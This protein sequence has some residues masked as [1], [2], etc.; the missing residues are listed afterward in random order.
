M[1]KEQA[2]RE[3]LLVKLQLVQHIIE[4][5]IQLYKNKRE[6]VEYLFLKAN[7][8]PDFTRIVWQRL[9][10]ESP[11]FF[12]AYHLRMVLRD[13][14]R[15]YNELYEK[16]VELVRR[17]GRSVPSS[18]N[19]SRMHSMHNDSGNQT[20]QP[21]ENVPGDGV[22]ALQPTPVNMSVPENVL[23][24]QHSIGQG[25]NDVMIGSNSEGGFMNNLIEAPNT[26]G[27]PYVTPFTSTSYPMETSSFGQ[28]THNFSP[29][30]NFS[31]DRSAL[32]SY[33]LQPSMQVPVSMSVPENMLLTQNSFGQ[34]MNSAMIESNSEGGFLNN[35]IEA[36]DTIGEAYVTPFTSTG[37]PM[38]T[39]SFG[40]T[41][42]NFSSTTNFSYDTSALDSYSLSAAMQPSMQVPVNMS[43]PE[44]MLSTQNTIG[45][46]MN[47]VMIGSNSGGGFAFGAENCAVGETSFTS[48]DPMLGQETSSF[49]QMQHDFSFF[50]GMS[51][52]S[53]NDTGGLESNSGSTFP[54]A[55]MDS[56]DT[57]WEELSSDDL[58]SLLNE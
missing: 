28:T 9:E 40:Q 44:N 58:F 19:G 12:Y 29:T 18:S 8:E 1:S 49:E 13:Q 47:D 36:P 46:G 20:R 5:C 35:L 23:L 42:H 53:S 7:I 2:A 17:T 11:K 54:D 43:L 15:I 57:K 33:S 31:Y 6:T 56:L 4:R 51:S 21:A 25:M 39:S 37:Y 32:D 14:I 30:T 16:Q 24:T 48:G 45:Q 26:I 27:E 3:A 41:A 50:S 22:P 38:E 10:K 55:E 34:G 52:Y